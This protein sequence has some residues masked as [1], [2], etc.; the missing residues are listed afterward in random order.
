MMSE[1][2]MLMPIFI[3]LAALI[4]AVIAAGVYISRK[5]KGSN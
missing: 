1:T 3:L 5:A 2:D 4:A